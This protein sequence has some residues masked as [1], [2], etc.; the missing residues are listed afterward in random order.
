MPKV[1]EE[2]SFEHASSTNITTVTTATAI[3][4]A[5]NDGIQLRYAGEVGDLIANVS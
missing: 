5:A 2:S 3:T 1:R 4:T